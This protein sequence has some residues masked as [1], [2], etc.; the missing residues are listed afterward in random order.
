MKDADPDDEFDC[1]ALLDSGVVFVECKTGKGDLYGEIE[2]FMR[3]DAELGAMHSFFVFDRDYTFNRGEDDTP[4]LSRQQ[5][6]DLGIQIISKVTVGT[7]R[8]FHITGRCWEH[9][10]D[11]NSFWPAL[12]SADSKVASGICFVMPARSRRQALRLLYSQSRRFHPSR[13]E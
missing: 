2:K 12:P 4:R 8:F 9:E 13:S 11:L 5:A 7:Q 10:E 6:F 3:R 1:V